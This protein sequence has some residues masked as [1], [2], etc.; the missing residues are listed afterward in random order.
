MENLYR[1][2]TIKDY[3]IHQNIIKEISNWL[4]DWENGTQKKPL[5]LMQPEDAFDDEL[6]F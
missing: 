1:P 3:G 6:E 4:V 5:I 2:N